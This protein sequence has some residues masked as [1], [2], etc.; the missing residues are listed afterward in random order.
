VLDYGCGSGIL[1]I[2]A[3]MLGAGR[4][5]GVDIDAKMAAV[6]RANDGLPGVAIA[7]LRLLGA[8]PDSPESRAALEENLLRKGW[9]GQTALVAPTRLRGAQARGKGPPRAR[10]ASAGPGA[11]HGAA[12]FSGRRGGVHVQRDVPPALLQ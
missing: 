8:L 10:Q 3:L 7:A 6:A 1:A 11:P 12:V 2:A 5:A 4:V 9:K